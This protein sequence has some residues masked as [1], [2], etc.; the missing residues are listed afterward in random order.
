MRQKKKVLSVEKNY[1]DSPEW[2]RQV[3]QVLS[4]TERGLAVEEINA[5]TDIQHTVVKRILEEEETARSIVQKIWTEKIPTMR[6]IVAMGLDGIRE[7]LKELADPER[8]REM[9]PDLGALEKLTKITTEI[10]LLLRLEEGK[11]T[12]NIASKHTHTVQ[13]VRHALMDLSK[14]D[15]VFGAAYD[16]ALALPSEENGS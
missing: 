12:A 6:D 3:K 10:N 1:R 16:A 11:S 8:R 4:L 2:K 14:Q 13:E 7:T 9:V 5:V 15:P